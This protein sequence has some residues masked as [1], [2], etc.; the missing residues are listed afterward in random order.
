MFM[1]KKIHPQSLILFIWICSFIILLYLNI[2]L[3]IPSIMFLVFGL[4]GLFLTIFRYDSIQQ[5]SRDAKFL[6]IKYKK[7]MNKQEIKLKNDEIQK[8]ILNFYIRARV[9]GKGAFYN[10]IYMDMII[11]LKNGT[12][13]QLHDDYIMN[14]FMLGV[15]KN[16]NQIK[17]LKT[18]VNIFER[19][20]NFSYNIK[21]IHKIYD[22]RYE[23]EAI[24][25]FINSK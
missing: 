10:I 19:C 13:F 23:P 20:E 17:S 15:G 6:Y 21:K 2:E 22:K 8:V 1:Y 7:G 25:S 5:I 12:S 9:K 3:L 11:E 24:K 14:G 16:V 4:V 18:L